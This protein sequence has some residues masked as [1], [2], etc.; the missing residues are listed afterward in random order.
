MMILM[1]I[2]ILQYSIYKIPKASFKWVPDLGT[3]PGHEPIIDQSCGAVLFFSMQSS[4][5]SIRQYPSRP[6]TVDL[7][8]SYGRKTGQLKDTLHGP[9]YEILSKPKFEY[10]VLQSR[11][12]RISWA[13]RGSHSIEIMMV[14]DRKT[15]I[16]KH[17]KTCFFLWVRAASRTTG[18]P[19][20]PRKTTN[21]NPE[22]KNKKS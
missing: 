14:Y 7:R 19:I 2:S 3:S 1:M 22:K 16:I 5:R 6:H 20:E 4:S 18:D 13:E 9:F 17:V 11:T 12:R 8:P 10:M 15:E 21:K